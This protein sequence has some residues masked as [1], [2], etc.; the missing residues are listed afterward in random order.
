MISG[1]RIYGDGNSISIMK[2]SP[3]LLNVGWPGAGATDSY[4][5]GSFLLPSFFSTDGSKN[6]NRHWDKCASFGRPFQLTDKIILHLGGNDMKDFFAFIDKMESLKLAYEFF[7]DPIGTLADFF[8]GKKR[9]TNYFFWYWQIDAKQN[10][11]VEGMKVFILKLL[12]SVNN[13]AEVLLVD[14]APLVYLEK[15]TF[16]ID[17]N[18]TFAFNLF[19]SR[20]N[21]KYYK[22]LY[23]FYNLHKTRVHFLDKFVHY[24]ENIAKHSMSYYLLGDG[25][26]FSSRDTPFDQNIGSNLGNEQFGKML[27]A[28][29]VKLG[30]FTRTDLLKDKDIDDLIN[31]VPVDLAQVIGECDLICKIAL[32]YFFKICK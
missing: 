3:T 9:S 10:E 28:K 1:S 4:D 18:K 27:A 16:Q 29:M 21:L 32:C 20:L 14:I 25:I 24:A 6:W 26:H 15:F 23:P 2:E 31:G 30:W 17:F 7:R 13:T 11:I 5:I 8:S 19:L 22:D 12:S